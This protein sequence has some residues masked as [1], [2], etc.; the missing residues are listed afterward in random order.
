MLLHHQRVADKDASPRRRAFLMHGILGSGNNWRTVA[1]RLVAQAPDW[2]FI[3]VDLRNHGRS[4]PAAPPH[5]LQACAQDLIEL[6]EHLGGAPEL[7]IG[8]S[9]GGKVAI[10][11]AEEADAEQVWVLDATPGAS[12][13][14]AE[15]RSEVAGVIRALRQVPVPLQRREE[16][17]DLL[18]GM[19]LSDMLSRWMTTNLTRGEGGLVW[20]FDLDAVEAM[21][22]DYLAQDLWHVLESP[23]RPAELHVVRAERSDRWTPEVLEHFEALPE[24]ARVHL[25][26][27][28]DAGH[29]LHVDNPGGLM[30]LLLRRALNG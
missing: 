27:L 9:Y 3:L 13:P 8:H 24:A 16:L 18:G 15:S 14:E 22:R 20:S 10:A 21:L 28:P 29:W 30:D 11:Y 17:L 5:T 6:G 19:G 7:V 2:E 12:T 23:W 26:L 25:H 1:R 4:H